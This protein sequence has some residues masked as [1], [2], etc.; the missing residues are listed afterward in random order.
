MHR[1]AYTYHKAKASAYAHAGLSAKARSHFRRA[2]YYRTAFGA[3]AK[4]HMI[5]VLS[6]LNA[7]MA[8]K[9]DAMLSETRESIEV[10]IQGF[11]DP[12]LY[13]EVCGDEKL[14]RDNECHNLLPAQFNQYSS[15]DP[16]ALVSL[17]DR[18]KKNANVRFVIVPTQLVKNKTFNGATKVAFKRMLVSDDAWSKLDKFVKRKIVAWHNKSKAKSPEDLHALEATFKKETTEKLD[19]LD[20]QPLF[21]PFVAYMLDEDSEKNLELVN[22]EVGQDSRLMPTIT[23]AAATSNVTF[24]RH[25]SKDDAMKDAENYAAY[26]VRSLTGAIN[27]SNAMSDEDVEVSIVQDWIDWD[28]LV[29]A[30]CILRT[31]PGIAT[32]YS[33]GRPVE[34]V[35]CG[36]VDF[37]APAWD[38][39]RPTGRPP[40]WPPCSNVDKEKST[41]ESINVAATWVAI[42]RQWR[43][44]APNRVLRVV[45]AGFTIRHGMNPATHSPIVDIWRTEIDADDD[46][47]DE[48]GKKGEFLDNL[49][50]IY[51]SR[52]Q[53]QLSGEV[54]VP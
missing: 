12:S 47:Y 11:S 28:N 4:K 21:D 38:G 10:Y 31:V 18:H 19:K 5:F 24:V 9:L 1:A 33:V 49:R 32:L 29:A 27:R 45:N 13:R 15:D 25:K 54:L 53:Q 30:K 48:A 2:A 3:P 35:G 16:L 17:I 37:A 34:S 20:F 6:P 23:Q 8:R 36:I 44:E 14:W 40:I 22:A 42:F 46:Y 51:D 7:P 43:K 50:R 26:L 41:Q 52:G 39:S